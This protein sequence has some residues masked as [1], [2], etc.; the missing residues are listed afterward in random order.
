MYI[1]MYINVDI[2]SI[3]TVTMD[4]HRQCYLSIYIL[5]NLDL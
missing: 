3:T 4:A 2:N 1:Y 5:Y